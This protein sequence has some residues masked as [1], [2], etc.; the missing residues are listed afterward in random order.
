[1]LSIRKISVYEL[2]RCSLL[3]VVVFAK[4]QNKTTYDQKNQFQYYST[5]IVFA[6]YKGALPPLVPEQQ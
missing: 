1:M 6:T 3:G 4:L 2:K 5:S